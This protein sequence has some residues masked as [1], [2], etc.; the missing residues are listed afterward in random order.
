MKKIII[1]LVLLSAW[2]PAYSEDYKPTFEEFF[3]QEIKQIKIQP[4][5][6]MLF[7][8]AVDI[9]LGMERQVFGYFEFKNIQFHLFETLYDHK[10]FIERN[11]IFTLLIFAAGGDA[12]TKLLDFYKFCEEDKQNSIIIRHYIDS[13][14]SYEKTTYGSSLLI[15]EKF[16]Q[17]RELS[18]LKIEEIVKSFNEIIYASEEARERVLQVYIKYS[19]DKEEEENAIRSEYY[20]KYHIQFVLLH[21][22]LGGSVGSLGRAPDVAFEQQIGFRL[23]YYFYNPSPVL[24]FGLLTEFSYYDVEDYNHKESISVHRKYLSFCLGLSL[25]VQL[26]NSDHAIHIGVGFSPWIKNY[27]EETYSGTLDGGDSQVLDYRSKYIPTINLSIEYLNLPKTSGISFFAGLFFNFKLAEP[28][29]L[30][31][32][33]SRQYLDYNYTFGGRVGLGFNLN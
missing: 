11:H 16:L 10:Q 19:R 23:N 33:N 5:D 21:F 4:Y 20:K 25:L 1:I 8:N 22:F 31:I 18:K 14:G 2:M 27:D 30:Y 29:E 12:E 9:F 6:K 26:K 7:S 17:F 13:R 3:Q 28:F 24:G 15:R 32:N